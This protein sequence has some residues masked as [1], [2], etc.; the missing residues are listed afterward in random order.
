MELKLVRKEF[1]NE[2]T[3]SELFVDGVKECFAIEDKDRNL[4]NAMTEEAIKCIK[5]HGKTAI[6]EGRYRVVI[7]YSNRFKKYLPE[8]LG[9]PGFAGIRIHAGNTAA[10]SEGCILPGKTKAADFVGSSKLAFDALFTKMKKA[11]KTEKIYLTV[12]K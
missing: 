4:N 10:D 9:V 11:E 1:T 2:S 5:V 7:S 8:V 3:I 12:C 6:P